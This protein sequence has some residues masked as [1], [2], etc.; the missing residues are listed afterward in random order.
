MPDPAAAAAAAKE[1]NYVVED[2]MMPERVWIIGP[3]K[4]DHLLP[5]GLRLGLRRPSSTPTSADEE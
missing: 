4:P 3:D 2:N 1:L 5:R